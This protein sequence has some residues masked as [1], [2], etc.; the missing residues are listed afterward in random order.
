MTWTGPKGLGIDMATPVESPQGP[1]KLTE[2]S[3]L[4]DY[5]GKKRFDEEDA[6][7]EDEEK[8]SA[9]HIDLRTNAGES[10]AF[11]KNKDEVTISQ[12]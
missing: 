4:P 6:E 3:N 8:E 1:T 2:D 12:K 7:D 11:D 9:K 5:D 10:I